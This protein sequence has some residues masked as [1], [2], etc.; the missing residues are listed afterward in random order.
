M[1]KKKV[2]SLLTAVAMAVTTMGCGATSETVSTPASQTPVEA[3][4]AR[5][6]VPS[7]TSLNLDDYS[8]FTASIKPSMSA[9]FSFRIMQRIHF[10]VFLPVIG[11]TLCSFPL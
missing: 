1:S 10:F 9:F 3:D 4:A 8:D 7:Y 5:G 6:E 11:E 2:L